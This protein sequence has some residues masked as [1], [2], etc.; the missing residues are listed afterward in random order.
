M[1]ENL[2][3]G[4]YDLTKKSRIQIFYK[5]NKTLIYSFVILIFIFL[6]GFFFYLEKKERKNIQLSESYIDAKIHIENSE[7]SEAKEILTEIVYENNQV[8]S[9]MSLFLMLDKK[10]LNE[11]TEITKLFDHVLQNNKFENEIRNLIIFKEIL[12]KSN[13]ENEQE[14]LSLSKPLINTNSLWKPHTLMLMGDYYLEKKE[15]LKAR[16]FYNQVLSI[17]N[18]QNEFYNQAKNQLIL[19]NSK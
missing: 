4:Q 15:Y 10:L 18:L 13:S 2:I 14:L 3:E 6:G 16:E 8:Y 11:N 1:T 9:V 7:L 17:Q 5:N 19:I 12:I